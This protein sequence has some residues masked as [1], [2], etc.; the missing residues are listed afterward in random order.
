LIV[1]D[2]EQG[3]RFL[4]LLLEMAGRIRIGAY[5]EQPEPFMGPLVSMPAAQKLLAAQQALK[6]A[7]GRILLEMQSLRK[8]CPFFLPASST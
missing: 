5:T 4:Q 3:R 6:A 1:S 8:S 7:G 2:D